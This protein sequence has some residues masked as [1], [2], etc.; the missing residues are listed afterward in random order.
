MDAPYFG[1]ELVKRAVILSMDRSDRERE[2][3][4]NMIA[5]FYST[6]LS[7]LQISEDR[8]LVPVVLGTVILLLFRR[9]CV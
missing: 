3:T 8:M 1:F 4:S 2:L 9:I 7:S 6:L 5:K